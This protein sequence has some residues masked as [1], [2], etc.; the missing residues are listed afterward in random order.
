VS[1]TAQV[2]RKLKRLGYYDGGVDG[3]IGPVTRRAIRGYQEENGLEIT[4]RIDQP[5]LRA[6]GL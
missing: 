6:L 1:L 5:L 4:G 2:Q 3:E